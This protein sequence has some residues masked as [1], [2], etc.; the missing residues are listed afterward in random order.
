MALPPPAPTSTCLVTG[1][2][3]GIGADI[4]RSLGARGYGVTLVARRAERL[5][6]LA[7]ELRA[8]RRV[9]VETVAC[10]LG[11][12]DARQRMSAEVE[13]RGLTVEVL[14]NNAGFGSAGRFQELDPA[15][16]IEMVRV[17]VEAVVDL[18]GRYVPEMARRGRGAVLNVASTAAF[19][20]LPRQATYAASKAF[21]LAF[22]DALHEDLAGTGVTATTL[23]PGPV[24]TE[25]ISTA[26]LRWDD[27]PGFIWTDSARVA[28]EGVTGMERGRRV[29]V[30]GPLN[31]ASALGGQHAP[32]GLLLRV[33][34]KVYPAG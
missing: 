21:V 16:E 30:P 24:K 19:Q 3:S 9:R 34:G 14:V 33:A 23:C 10:D 20:P 5:E 13:E 2:S 8:P 18:C 25:F 32:R 26:G 1:A 17:N 31:R 29:V 27:M 4:A 6:A 11:D 7:R 12:A 22:T 15:R 28:E